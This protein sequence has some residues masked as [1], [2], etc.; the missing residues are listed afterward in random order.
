MLESF[1]RWEKLEYKMAAFSKSQN[2]HSK[3]PK[4]GLDTSKCQ[5]KKQF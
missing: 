4:K 2:F 1:G 5:T 3:M